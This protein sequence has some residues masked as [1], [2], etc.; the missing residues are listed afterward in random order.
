MMQKMQLASSHH[1]KLN[2]KVTCNSVQVYSFSGNYIAWMSKAFT[3]DD[4]EWI[5]FS[6]F[7][8]FIVLFVLRSEKIEEEGETEK[9]LYASWTS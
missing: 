9:D 3:L 7:T 2:K 8:S 5:T 1:T 4:C 6:L